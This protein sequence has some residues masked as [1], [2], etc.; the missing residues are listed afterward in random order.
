MVVHLRGDEIS[1]KSVAAMAATSPLG[2]HIASSQRKTGDLPLHLRALRVQAEGAHGNGNDSE[3]A[4]CL[5]KLHA[6][7]TGTSRQLRQLRRPRL[8]AAS[9]TSKMPVA[10]VPRLS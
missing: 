9:W 7:V 6:G 5:R 3:A 4:R 8:Q 1:S 2:M 10:D